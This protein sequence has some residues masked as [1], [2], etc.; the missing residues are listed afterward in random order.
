MAKNNVT[1]TG[2]VYSVILVLGL[3]LRLLH[4]ALHLNVSLLKPGTAEV[5]QYWSM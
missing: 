3:E 5:Q 4:F 2:K 1:N